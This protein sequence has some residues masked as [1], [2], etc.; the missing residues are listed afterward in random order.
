MISSFSSFVGQERAKLALL[1]N[2]V[3]SRCGG[4]LFVG[5]RGCGKST[6]ARCFRHLLPAEIPLIEM[7]LNVTEEAIVGGIDFERTIRTGE[8]K[9]QSSLLRRAAGGFLYIDDVNLLAEDLLTLV[10]HY[11][12]G[13]MK[14]GAGLPSSSS[15]GFRL[16]ASMTPETPLSSH[17]LDRFGMAVFWK[18]IDGEE[19]RRRIVRTAEQ[20]EKSSACDPRDAQLRE[21][22]LQAKKRLSAVQVSAAIE[23]LIAERC[24]SHLVAG[25][26]GDIF[27]YYGARAYAALMGKSEV[28]QED[29][30]VV[31]PLVLEHR[32][33]VAPPEEQQQQKNDEKKAQQ[34]QDQQPDE[35]AP[36]ESQNESRVDSQP[37]QQDEQRDQDASRTR[38]S[39]P[40]EQVFNIGETFAVRRLQFSRDRVKRGSS[41]RKIRTLSKDKRGRYVK[42]TKRGAENDIAIDATIRA[43]APW[44]RIRGAQKML[45]IRPEDIQYKQREK[46]IGHMTVFVV[47]GSGSMGAQ[48]RMQSTKGAIQSLL[49]DSYQKRDKVAMIVFRRDRAELVLPPTSSSQRAARLLQQIPVGGKTPLSAGLWAAHQLIQRMQ[50]RNPETRFLLT[51]ISDCKANQS[52]SDV[53]PT[54]EVN[55]VVATLR[56]LPS[57][58]F[59]VVDTENSSSFVRTGSAHK[60]A[61]QLAAQYYA[62]DKLKAENLVTLFHS[63]SM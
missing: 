63:K 17:A 1:L 53:S 35:N 11:K 51:L 2:A 33:R 42:S 25:H 27:L 21:S 39:L 58:E 44:Q 23:E 12:A 59:L 57:T 46:R 48:N 41:G 36:Q 37:D 47:D 43:A 34:P 9:F 22:V 49:L 29:V 32:Q 56:E 52:M 24:I 7:P 45:S 50:R 55:R 20:G 4:V 40:R 15:L 61:A 54:E 62:M 6:L 19:P 60:I 3:D 31:L 8:R 18:H 26:R 13:D 16:I 38:I 30:E 14:D 5:E 10:L 28:S